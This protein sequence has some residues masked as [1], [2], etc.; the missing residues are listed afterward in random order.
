L[1]LLGIFCHKC[2]K[3]LVTVGNNPDNY[4]LSGN[5]K[6]IESSLKHLNSLTLL[7]YLV[8]TLVWA[9]IPTAQVEPLVSFEPTTGTDVIGYPQ[10]Q[11]I[12]QEFDEDKQAH[13][14]NF[15]NGMIPV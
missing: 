11:A 12:M 7:V 10:V 1:H 3:R 15:G 5:R 8:N 9:F 6:L 14:Q 2:D 4:L 13:W